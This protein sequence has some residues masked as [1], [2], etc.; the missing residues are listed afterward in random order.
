MGQSGGEV[1][2]ADLSSQDSISVMAEDCLSLAQ[3]PFKVAGHSMGA[4]V[5]MEMARIAP[6][7]IEHL[8]LLDTGIHPLKKDEPEKRE[9]IVRFAHEN[10]MQALAER[11]LPGMVYEPNRRNK[12]LMQGLTDMVLRH[13]PDLHERQNQSACEQARCDALPVKHQMSGTACGRSPRRLEPGFATQRYACF[14]AKCTA[15]NHRKCRPLCASGKSVGVHR[16][17][18]KVFRSMSVGNIYFVS[19]G[20]ALKRFHLFM[21]LYPAAWKKF[22]HSSGVKR[23]QISPMASMS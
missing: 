14:V 1:L 9:A 20:D 6:E 22:R 2:V 12:E 10:G 15:R 11:W 19:G 3:G 18:R 17:M 16:Y 23:S 7:R 21:K 4:R 13:D 5:A 8:I